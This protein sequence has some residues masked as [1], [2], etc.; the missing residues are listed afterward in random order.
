MLAIFLLT[1]ILSMVVKNEFDIHESFFWVVGAL[2]GVFL[3]IFP[4][5]IDKIAH[6]LGIEYSPSLFLLIC[7][8]FLIFINFRL[9]KLISKEKEK[10]MFLAQ[11]IS[12]L[13]RK[14]ENMEN[15]SREN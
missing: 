5:S 3:S 2:I 7:I 6:I 13:K 10:V 4:K 9:S 12:I 15:K 14:I 11:E 8:I 1:Y